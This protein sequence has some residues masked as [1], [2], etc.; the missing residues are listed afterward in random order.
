VPA[1]ADRLPQAA[2]ADRMGG[3]VPTNPADKDELRPIEPTFVIDVAL[4]DALPRAGGL[5]RVRLDLKPQSLLVTASQRLR[6]LLLK[7]FSDVKA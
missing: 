6:Q 1:A 5:A 2:M 4:D 3:R 7:H